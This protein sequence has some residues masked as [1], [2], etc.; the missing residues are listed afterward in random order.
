M[1]VAL[2]VAGGVAF[3]A[4]ITCTTNPCVGTRG[5]DVI[6][7]TD[8]EETI[9]ARAGDDQVS[10]LGRRDKLYGQDGGDSLFGGRGGDT[11][12][13]GPNGF[14]PDFLCGES[15]NDKLVESAGNDR[16]AFTSGWGDDVILG[17]EP[18]TT[19]G[20]QDSVEF[21]LACRSGSALNSGVT[22][23]LASGT[24][25][26]GTNTVS[27]D[28]GVI[29]GALGGFSNDTISGNADE[30]NVRGHEGAD[31]LDVSGDPPTETE[32]WIDRADCG[33]DTD[34]DSVT[35]DEADA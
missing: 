18:F 12:D 3:A 5:G 11:L 35:I 31:V 25:T 14:I 2:L 20:L 29:E 1:G 4:A 6:T 16:Y 34:A 19:A 9:K 30:N 17:G 33:N 24:A 23:D 32:G 27:W 22:I 21:A 15:Q 13:G 10:G 8:S 26:D 28:P 7:G